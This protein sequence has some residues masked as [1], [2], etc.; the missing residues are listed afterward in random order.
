MATKLVGAVGVKF[1]KSAPKALILRC[2]GTLPRRR[3]LPVQRLAA[4][5]C[6]EAL[7]L[8]SF[9]HLEQHEGGCGATSIPGTRQL[10][11]GAVGSR[12]S[13]RVGTEPLEHHLVGYPPRGAGRARCAPSRPSPAAPEVPAQEGRGAGQVVDRPGQEIGLGL[14]EMQEVRH[15]VTLSRGTSP[16]G[17]FVGRLGDEAARDIRRHRAQRRDDGGVEGFQRDGPS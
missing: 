5:A 9:S 7:L 1:C 14:S 6:F 11:R 12:F 15:V 13:A 17:A 3:A 8:I 10:G 4:G 16:V 2:E